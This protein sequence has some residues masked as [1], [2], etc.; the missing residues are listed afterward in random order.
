MIESLLQSVENFDHLLLKCL[1]ILIITS[2][3]ASRK[4]TTRR[5][6]LLAPNFGK[7]ILPVLTGILPA[8]I[9]CKQATLSSP[10]R[11]H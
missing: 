8:E 6:C 3:A 4:V 2:A 10:A 5:V 1:V 7:G 11:G 9:R